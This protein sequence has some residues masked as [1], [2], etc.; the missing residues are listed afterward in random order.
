M[1]AG[2]AAITGIA[3]CDEASLVLWQ[4]ILYTG[5]GHTAGHYPQVA[6]ESYSVWCFCVYFIYS[7]VCVY[8]YL[9]LLLG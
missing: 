6:H 4:L 5:K 3:F 2:S 8:V 9:Y 1:T 7:C